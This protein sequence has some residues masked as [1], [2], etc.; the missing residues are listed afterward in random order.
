MNSDMPSI[1]P[2]YFVILII[3]LSR[4]RNKEELIFRYY[5]YI[6]NILYSYSHLSRNK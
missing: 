3:D 6:L 4:L 2:R 1:V 5:Y